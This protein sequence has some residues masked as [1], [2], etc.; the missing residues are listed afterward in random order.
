M[1]APRTTKRNGPH[2]VKRPDII[3]AALRKLTTGWHGTPDA[4]LDAQLRVLA[5]HQPGLREREKSCGACGCRRVYN[6]HHDAYYCPA[7][8]RWLELACR[9]PRCQRC[10]DRPPHPLAA[11]A[12]Q[13]P[14]DYGVL[15]LPRQMSKA[16][17]ARCRRLRKVGDGSGESQPP[18]D[19]NPQYGALMSSNLM[20]IASG[21]VRREVKATFDH[22]MG[23][24]MVGLPRYQREH[25]R[26]GLTY[27]ERKQVASIPV[28]GK[29]SLTALRATLTAAGFVVENLAL[30]GEQEGFVYQPDGTERVVRETDAEVEYTIRQMPP[31][32]RLTEPRGPPH[33][34]PL[35]SRCRVRRWLR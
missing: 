10:A 15:K 3:L 26:P 6:R 18:D 24:C 27:R 4:L 28:L 33:R 11:P 32:S 5:R 16:V 20:S 31:R 30:S 25:E 8:N 29:P 21:R 2:P 35:F 19:Y 12:A 13:P 17:I 22:F 14:D 23:D 34:N 7:C 9:N 1:S